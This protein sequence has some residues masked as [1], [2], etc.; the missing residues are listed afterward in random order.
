MKYARH[1]VVILIAIFSVNLAWAYS[2]SMTPTTSEKLANPIALVDVC[3][4]VN[5][6]EWRGSSNLGPTKG[7]IKALKRHCKNAM[8]A[9]PKF[10]KSKGYKLNKSG[11]LKTSICLIP[12]NDSPRNLNDVKHRFSSRTKTYKNGE[13]ERIWGYFQRHTNHVYLRNSAA[14][15]HRVVF[16]HELFHAASYYYGI[17]G[18]H[19]GN[20]D[21]KE[22]QMAQDFTAYLGYG[23]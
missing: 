11:K 5:I 3:S 6:V 23:R 14:G 12:M 13:V 21:L 7:N 19:S 20:K 10:I 2:S 18:Q 17:Y 9:F 22:E 8:M 4:D 1:L 15:S 16:V